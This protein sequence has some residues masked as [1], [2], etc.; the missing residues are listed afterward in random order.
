MSFYEV[1]YTRGLSRRVW[2]ITSDLREAIAEAQASR[3]IAQEMDDLHPVGVDM[4]DGNGE[5]K[6]VVTYNRE[7]GFFQR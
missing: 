1:W 3:A 7:E 5:R 4:I 2:M 6:T